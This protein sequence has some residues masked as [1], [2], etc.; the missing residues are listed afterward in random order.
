MWTLWE[1][2]SSRCSVAEQEMRLGNW[3]WRGVTGECPP[4]V[5]LFPWPVPRESLP[6]LEA[7]IMGMKIFLNSDMQKSAMC[8]NPLSHTLFFLIF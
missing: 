3:I 7:G 2:G 1:E 8:E 5:Y 4:L 6:V